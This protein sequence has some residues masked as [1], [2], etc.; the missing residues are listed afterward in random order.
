MSYFYDYTIGNKTIEMQ[1]GALG[2]DTYDFL[3]EYLQKSEV[4]YGT[5]KVAAKDFAEFLSKR[6]TA[7][8]DEDGPAFTED[9]SFYYQDFLH[10]QDDITELPTA[11]AQADAF[12]HADYLFGT[13]VH[14]MTATTA[15]TELIITVS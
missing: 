10:F 8:V 14:A 5:Y 9:D 2:A 11:Q 4:P 6:H 13:P 3:A 12:N 15:A 7:V 1:Q